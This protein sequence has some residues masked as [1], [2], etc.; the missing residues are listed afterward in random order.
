MAFTSLRIH[1]L[2]NIS[3]LEISPSK[4]INLFF[5][6][7]GAG[8]TSILEAAYLLARAKSFRSSRSGPLIKKGEGELT[9]FGNYQTS[10]LQYALGVRKKGTD[11]E[12]R[13]NGK[14]V[15]RTS[16]IA[17]ILPV[18]IITPQSHQI[19]ERGPEFRRRFIEWG[20]F[21]VEHRYHQLYKRY[22]RAL[23]QRNAAIKNRSDN[24]SVWDRELSESGERLNAM[25]IHYLEQLNAFVAKESSDLLP[26]HT[27]ELEWRQ[28]W[29][30]NRTFAEALEL[31]FKSDAEKGYTQVGPHRA[32]LIVRLDGQKAINVASRG[33]QK[34]IVMALKLAQMTTMKALVS[35]SPILLLDDLGAELDSDNLFIVLTRLK[36]L[37]VQTFITSTDKRAFDDV[38][39]DKLFH[40]EHGALMIC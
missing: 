31:Q 24:I 8:K 20:V 1:N 30:K 17:R 39:L 15:K 23:N 29:D 14:T 12:I 35:E 2:R 38:A 32:D 33:Q 36:Q 40:V 19:L 27:V 26:Q 22:T 10:G 28:G 13:M 3:N 11:T 4:G 5:G 6:K 9:V 25:R 7:N 34:L 21:H 18:Q 37:S 16:E